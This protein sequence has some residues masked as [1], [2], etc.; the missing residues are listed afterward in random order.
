MRCIL[1]NVWF[2]FAVHVSVF[3]QHDA[4]VN[5]VDSDGRRQGRWVRYYEHGTVMYDGRFRDGYPD[6][7]FVRFY[8]NGMRQSE[9][10]YSDSGTVADAVI[11]HPNGFVAARGR[12]VNRMKVG[13]WEFYS[14]FSDG[15]V[16]VREWYEDNMR[17]GVSV[18]MY[19]DGVVAERITYRNDTA[20]G[21]WTKFYNSG[22]I[23]LRTNV[24]DGMVDGRFEAWFDN[25]QLQFSGMYVNDRRE[26]RWLIYGRDG[27]LRYELNYSGGV[28]T[29]RGMDVDVDG[30]LDALERDA[31][32]IPDPEQEDVPF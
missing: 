10:A 31:G 21:E 8:G 15:Y 20:S 14:R 13:E 24:V 3:G 2:L 12:Y 16:M 30:Y 11:Y 18:K 27:A 28:T 7:L 6:G 22:S 9:L 23:N 19:E 25:G 17:N 4:D 29:D 1:Y 5:V 26:G 32:K